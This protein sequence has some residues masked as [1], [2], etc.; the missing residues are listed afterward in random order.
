MTP[1]LP[2]FRSHQP[3]VGDRVVARRRLPGASVHWTDV[4]GHVIGVNPLVV[5]PQTV[6]GMPS[7]AEEIVIPDEQLE[8][9]KILSPRTIRN[10]DIRAVEV[11]TAKAFPGLVNEWSDGWLL[12]AGDGIA[13]RSN[14]ASPLGPSVGFEP[15]PI[16]EIERFYASHD[17][18]VRVHIPER[19]GRPAQKIIDAAPDEWMMG[20]EIVVMT[21]GLDELS[22]AELPGDLE[23]S[24]EKQPDQDWLDMYH[25]RGQAL[26]PQALELLRTQID[27]HMG[28]GRLTTHAGQTV[29][30][31]RA[32]ITA[33]EERTFLGYS[34]VE[35]A[36]AFRRQGLGTALGARI[37]SW[38]AT[39]GAEE[40]YLQVIAHNEAGI[41]LYHKLGFSEHH[42][43]RYAQR[44]Y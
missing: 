37:Q 11:A 5:R 34:A 22:D 32:T 7:T 24:V 30:I 14:S 16:A 43:H 41:G 28:F 36:P 8:V 3:K 2:R 1:S 19:I 21:K 38:A 9:V 40:A 23:F 33:A 4:I 35:V 12:R 27:G 26:P 39:Q 6:G 29:A 44:K 42:R 25:F 13:E 10:S 20:P 31:T 15:V 18:P 17:L